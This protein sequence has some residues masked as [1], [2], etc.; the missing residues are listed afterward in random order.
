MVE[1]ATSAKEK[2]M[3]ICALLTKS[4]LHAS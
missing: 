1:F 2:N 3:Y 4:L